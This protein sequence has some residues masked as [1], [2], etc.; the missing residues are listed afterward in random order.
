MNHYRTGCCASNWPV[1]RKCVLVSFNTVA[2]YAGFLLIGLV[3]VKPLGGY[4]ARVFA[5]QK[6]W[7]DP[8]LRPIE[9]FIFALCRIDAHQEMTG[10]QYALAFVLF[11]L[12]GTLVLYAILRLQQFLPFYDPVHLV[13]PIDT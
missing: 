9:R 8:A 5:G 6:T 7:L 4:M 11:S 12:A 3:L 2:L 1:V 13:T 10:K